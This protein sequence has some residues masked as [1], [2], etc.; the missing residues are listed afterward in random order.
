MAV[1]TIATEQ[2]CENPTPKLLGE[3]YG[4]WCQTLVLLLAAIF[5]Y[6]AIRASRAIERR[7]AAI[8]AIASARRDSKLTSNVRRVAQLHENERSIAYYGRKDQIDATEAKSIRYALNHYEYVA[9][10][11]FEDMY[12]EDIF[13]S[14]VYSTV[15]KLY[16]RTKPFIDEVRTVSKSDTPFQEFECLA[17]RWKNNPLEHKPIRAVEAK[18]RWSLPWA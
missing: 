18:K 5:A 7:K 14:A 1:E 9:V 11:I 12:D 16:D 3:T 8:A 15:V 13:K 10:G 2:Q 4:F 17:C 6:M